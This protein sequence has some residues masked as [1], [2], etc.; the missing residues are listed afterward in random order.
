MMPLGWLHGLQTQTL[1]LQRQEVHHYVIAFS[2]TTKFV[3]FKSHG[4]KIGER[5]PGLIAQILLKS[6]LDSK[7]YD[8]FQ[9]SM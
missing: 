8:V 1:G 7:R 4:R 2:S 3:S 6:D 9:M 5:L